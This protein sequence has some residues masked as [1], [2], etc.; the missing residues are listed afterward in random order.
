VRSS[1]RFGKSTEAPFAAKADDLEAIRDAVVDAASV[2]GGLWI[3][4]LFVL[5][6][7]LIAAG[8]VTHKDL[9]LEN[10]VKLPF[11]N[12]DLPLKGFFWLGPAIFLIVHTYVLM[13]FVLLVGKVR[14][15]DAALRAQIA[16]EAK[17]EALRRQLPS[18]V[19]VQ[20]LAGPREVRRQ[21]ERKLAFRDHATMAEIVA[22][23]TV[24]A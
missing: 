5:F 24:A 3:S 23:K 19:F 13:H 14:V 9:F 1:R 6:Y 8:G 16:D 17:R 21:P 2:S 22:E 18:N 4:Y 11:L 7:L 20:F 15:L 12:V 10:P